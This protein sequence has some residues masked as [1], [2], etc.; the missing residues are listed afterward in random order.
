V[1]YCCPCFS[2]SY[3]HLL[4][5][6][7]IMHTHRKVQHYGCTPSPTG[8]V[9]DHGGPFI[10]RPFVLV[11]III[12]ATARPA[13]PGRLGRVR[14]IARHCRSTG[15][16]RHSGRRDDDGDGIESAPPPTSHCGLVRTNGSSR[17]VLPSKLK[18]NV[19]MKVYSM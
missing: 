14:N 6:L 3:H 13:R 7:E 8:H 16:Q 11:R 2:D 10:T 15:T 18:K 4:S 9:A 12:I 17:A 19:N 5:C 1:I